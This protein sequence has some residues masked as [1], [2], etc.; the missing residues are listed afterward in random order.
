MV[1]NFC[2]HTLILLFALVGFG[3]HSQQKVIL[4]GIDG[5]GSYAFEKAEIPNIRKLMRQGSYSLE[6]RCVLP[7]SSAVNWVSILT[8]SPSELHGFTTWGSKV[9]EIPP[10]AK[11][12]EDI[13]P[14]IFSLLEEQKPKE[15]KGAIYTWGGIEHLIETSIVDKYS[16]PETDASTFN[17]A[18]EFILDQ[19]PAFTF[20]HL[21]EPDHTGHKIG[22]DTPS[23]YAALEKVDSL[24]GL[25]FERLDEQNIDKDYTIIL[26]ADHGGVGKG[27]GGK[28]L[29]EMQIPWI[30][31]GKGIKKNHAI[32]DPIITYDTG[33]TIA[34][35]LELKTPSAWR[36]KVVTDAFKR[37]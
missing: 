4:I 30:I 32:L 37:P 14:T 16:N 6:A 18:A 12:E 7:S 26:T 3:A 36:G 21:D 17:K 19:D 10:I 25:F 2:K 34:K 22:H 29:M 31:V 20:I 24:L 9:P 5:L 11:G 1:P 23:Y 27:H 28:S 33:A 8:G 13:F 15:K 35:I